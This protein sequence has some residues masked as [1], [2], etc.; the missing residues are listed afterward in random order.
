MGIIDVIVLAT[1]VVSVLFALYRGLLRELL[2][3]TSWILAG[4]AA[5]YTYQPILEFAKG[6]E[7]YIKKW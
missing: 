5:L 4:L 2:G 7:R 3:I 6:K 1:M